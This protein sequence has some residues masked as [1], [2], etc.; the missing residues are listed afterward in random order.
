MRCEDAEE[1]ITALVDQELLGAERSAVEIHLGECQRCALIYREERALKE[2]IR[3]FAAGVSAP[4]HLKERIVADLSALPGEGTPRRI[5]R[6]WFRPGRST[7]WPA[8]AAAALVL[9]ALPVVQLMQP[10]E[11]IGLTTL[12]THEK[13][14]GGGAALVRAAS[15]ADVKRELSRSVEDQFAPMG[16]DLSAMNL[17]V[18]GGLVDEVKGRKVLVTLY[19]G[20]N[21]SLTCYT[22]LGTE[23]DAPQGAALFF[24]AQKKINFYLFSRGGVNGVLHREGNVICIL[25]SRMPLS[26]LLEVARSKARPS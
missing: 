12:A 14:I 3:R 23:R 16:Y 6:E 2:K 4:A 24:D 5:W 17:R 10:R 19:E 20:E 15:P 13:V 7:L 11:Q 8:L 1:L 25:V 26:D 22:F 9:L 21:P 18:V